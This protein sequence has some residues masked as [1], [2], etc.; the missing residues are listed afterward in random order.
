L[1]AKWFSK[2]IEASEQIKDTELNACAPNDLGMLYAAGKGVKQDDDQA[3]N[4][5]EKAGKNLIMQYNDIQIALEEQFAQ[6]DDYNQSFKEFLTDIL[7]AF[8][9]LQMT[10][11]KNESEDDIH[12]HYQEGS[13]V[14]A[15]LMAK[16]ITERCWD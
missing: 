16:K 13:I 10:K 14:L 6:K 9:A 4:L 1:A 11:S 5:L 12:A 8:V 15:K 2:S 3:Q 7:S